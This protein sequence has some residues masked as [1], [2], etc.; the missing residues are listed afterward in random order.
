MKRTFVFFYTVLVALGLVA[1]M[2]A[3]SL[4]VGFIGT[5]FSNEAIARTA[6]AF[7]KSAK[8]KGWTPIMLNSAGSVKTQAYQ[9]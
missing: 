3:Q 1:S 5:N 8:A 4:T 2:N 9:L 7:E 6:N